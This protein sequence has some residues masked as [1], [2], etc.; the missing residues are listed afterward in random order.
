MCQGRYWSLEYLRSEKLS[1]LV[2]HVC[3]DNECR[4]TRGVLDPSKRS[5]SALSI[6]AT[7]YYLNGIFLTP[8]DA[9]LEGREL[10]VDR[11]QA[12]RITVQKLGLQSNLVLQQYSHSFGRYG[13]N[14]AL[15]N[16]MGTANARVCLVQQ[17][18]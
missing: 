12:P 13:A 5:P 10:C 8:E 4:Y 11:V 14:L 7:G 6:L 18:Y 9:I 3:R 17:K 2:M 16:R 1:V 15:K